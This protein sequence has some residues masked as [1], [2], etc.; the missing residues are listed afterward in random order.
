MNRFLQLL[1]LILAFGLHAQTR[2]VLN[3]GSASNDGTGES[4]RSAFIKSNANFSNLWAT[5][6]TNGAPFP[7]VT[8]LTRSWEINGGAVGSVT[9]SVSFHPLYTFEA[10]AT[11]L[12]LVGIDSGLLQGNT[13]EIR[14]DTNLLVLTPS[15]VA[16]TAAT[17]QVLKLSSSS[18]G[19]SEF[20]WPA[21][22]GTVE[23]VSV[24]AISDLRA[25]DVTKLRDGQAIR[26]QGYYTAGDGGAGTYQYVASSSATHDGG[27]TIQPNTGSGRFLL[28]QMITQSARQWGVKGDGTDETTALQAALNATAAASVALYLPDGTYLVSALAPYNGC[29]VVGN[30]KG[31][32]IK[33]KAAST[34]GVF[35]ATPGSP[36]TN[37]YIADLYVDGN[38]AN[39]SSS[40]DHFRMGG[41]NIVIE[42]VTIENANQAAINI[43]Y[44]V[45]VDCHVR[46][47]RVINPANS[48][49]GYGGIAFTHVLNGSIEGCMVTSTEGYMTYGI[50]VEPNAY[51]ASE[52]GNIV[53]SNNRVINGQITLACQS[54]T[55]GVPSNFIIKGNVVDNSSGKGANTTQVPPLV[56]NNV[57]NVTVI[58]NTFLD[59]ATST[60]GTC[61]GVYMQGALNVDISGNSFTVRNTAIDENVFS[62]NTTACTGSITGNSVLGV[63]A[64]ST[65]PRFFTNGR[66]T[67]G[68]GVDFNGNSVQ[69]FLQGTDSKAFA[70]PMN[71]TVSNTT[72]ETTLIGTSA[73]G[74]GGSK[75]VAANTMTVGKA[76]RVTFGGLISTGSGGST[77]SIKVK[78]GAT[79]LTT[80]TFT[81]TASQSN[82][83]WFCSMIV[84]GRSSTSSGLVTCMG[85]LTTDCASTTTHPMR[86]DGGTSI[87][88][89]VDNAWNVTM[90]WGAGVTASDSLSCTTFSIEP[91]N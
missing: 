89:S 13:I 61:R 83:E 25:L 71:V 82:K 70:G 28:R 91:I 41:T 24:T 66:E 36:V 26:T 55:N 15:V 7:A 9:N 38:K 16:G 44:D 32:I 11:N 74:Y 65:Q 6:Y 68:I 31:S 63:T 29:R 67:Y 17:G 79:T 57:Q 47:C 1:G 46:N 88:N 40:A 39:A 90:T 43:G 58:G 73:T 14:A 77:V 56:L 48:S 62:F 10:A 27:S 2:S 20:G 52:N 42:R 45:S 75:Y 21:P 19:S 37:V 4:L 35:R 84:T 78:L 12:T 5:V 86:G 60:S 50:D 30:G 85:F 49:N 18:T 33:L 3:V 51:A 22:T 81:P 23:S 87:D 59:H 76:Y 80:T 54:A 72:T 34:G 69:N 64:S 53:I 8:Y